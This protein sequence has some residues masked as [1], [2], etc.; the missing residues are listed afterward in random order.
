MCRPP[1]RSRSP[2]R[3]YSSIDDSRTRSFGRQSVL[4]N[5]FLIRYRYGKGSLWAFVIADSAEQVDARFRDIEIY[6]GPPD[7]FD[8]ELEAVIQTYPIDEPAGWLPLVVRRQPKT[9]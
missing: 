5:K 3:S 1:D 4:D 6:D 7:W 9:E 2:K 8:D